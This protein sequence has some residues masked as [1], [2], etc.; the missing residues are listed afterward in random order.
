MVR[1]NGDVFEFQAYDVD[2]VLFD[3]LR[4]ERNK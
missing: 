1:I 4:Y 2:G 3:S